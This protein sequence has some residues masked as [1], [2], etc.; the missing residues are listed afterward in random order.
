MAVAEPTESRAPLIYGLSYCTA[1]SEPPQTH[2]TTLGQPGEG[3]ESPRRRQQQGPG[4]LSRAETDTELGRQSPEPPTTQAK[5]LFQ[6]IA[7][8]GK[9]PVAVPTNDRCFLRGWGRQFHLGCPCPRAL[10]TLTLT[11]VSQGRASS[12]TNNTRLDHKPPV[13]PGQ[14]WGAHAKSTGKLLGAVG[15]NC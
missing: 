8:A 1:H 13:T 11:A 14:G 7:R 4:S 5:L 12:T 10:H 2:S 9:V 3:R 6:V 15:I